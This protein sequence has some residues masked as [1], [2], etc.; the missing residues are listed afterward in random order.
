LNALFAALLALAGVVCGG[1]PDAAAETVR[2]VLASPLVDVGSDPDGCTGAVSGLGGPA[3]WQVQLE[4]SLLDGKALVET[5]RQASL[6][7]YPLCIADRP[8]AKNA[9]VELSFVAHDGG[10]ARTAGLVLRFSDPQDFYVVEADAIAGRVRLLRVRNGEQRDVAASPATVTAGEAHTLKVR[11]EDDAFV[12][13]LDGKP[14]FETRD[15]GI[16]AAGRF[17]IWSRADSRT[18]F[19]DLFIAVLD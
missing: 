10:V 4:R 6:D 3:V 11:A 9:E 2:K 8:V 14:V 15:D 17:G 5:S 19:G 18:G 7:R 13:S 16:A 12:V 1:A